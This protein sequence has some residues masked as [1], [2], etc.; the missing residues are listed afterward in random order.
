[1]NYWNALA[2]QCLK[3]IIQIDTTTAKGYEHKA[4]HYIQT[5][6]EEWNIQSEIIYSDKGDANLVVELKAT[7]DTSLAPIVLLSHVDV[8]EAD[9]AEWDCGPFS[10]EERDGVLYGRGT[11]DTKQLTAMH[12]VMMKFLNEHK[13]LLNRD[14]LF[15]AT[16]DEESGS[17]GGMDY[18]ANHY[19]ILFEDTDVLNEGGGF[20][21]KSNERHFMLYAAGEKGRAEV[22]LV[23]HGDGGT[24]ANAPYNQAIFKMQQALGDILLLEQGRQSNTIAKKFEGYFHNQNNEPL[25]DQLQDYMQKESIKIKKFETIQTSNQIPEQV[26]V[27]LEVKLF[28]SRLY[29]EF[30]SVLT[31]LLH[32]HDIRWDIQHFTPGYVCDLNGPLLKI[33][34]EKTE[35]YGYITVPFIALGNTDGRFIGQMANGIYGFSPVTIRFEEVLKRVHQNNERIEIEAFYFGVKLMLEIAK[36]YCIERG[37]ENEL[38]V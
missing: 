15:V 29:E 16:A 10:A 19:S 30:E 31:H 34:E 8:V 13:N 11:L 24:S 37:F 7:T 17:R 25:I 14:V 35:N 1:M 27:L 32:K 4:I 28:P 33:C 21:V 22:K 20:L 18:L 38:I 5:I 23:A 6:L 2:L 12:M 36:E 9:E 3:Q 26:N